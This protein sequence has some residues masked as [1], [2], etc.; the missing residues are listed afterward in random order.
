MEQIH[1]KIEMAFPSFGLFYERQKNQYFD[2]QIHDRDKII[3]LPYLI[4]SLIAVMLRSPDQARG[5]P[6]SFGEKEYARMFRNSDRPD[7]YANCAL[8]MK[9][10]EKFLKTRAV[11]LESSYIYNVKFYVAMYVSCLILQDA[12][13][14]RARLTQLDI[15]KATDLFLQES[16]EHV[17]STFARLSQQEEPDLVAKGVKMVAELNTELL[18]KF[19]TKRDRANRIKTK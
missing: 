9:R 15:A 4:Q 19:G 7:I 11:S 18:E 16:L 17:N 1:E 8:L 13:P 2:D 10:V 6:T 12:E 14:P 5:R 3:T